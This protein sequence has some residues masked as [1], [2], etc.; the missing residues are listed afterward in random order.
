MDDRKSAVITFPDLPA[1][2]QEDIRDAGLCAGITVIDGD[3]VG[4]FEPD[5][6]PKHLAAYVGHG[7]GLCTHYENYT[8]CREEKEALPGRRLVLFEYTE[9]AL[10]LHYDRISYAYID[11]SQQGYMMSSFALG[12]AGGTVEADIQDF[13]LYFLRQHIYCYEGSCWCEC[14]KVIT[15]IMTGTPDSLSDGRAR[16][17]VEEAIELFGSKPEIFDSNPDFVAARGAAEMGWRATANITYP[18]GI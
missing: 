14:P 6:P 16:Q 1:L 11:H 10:L 8:K 12:S 9:T 5:S 13:F 17:A 2:Y 18:P 3:R 4:P 7:M 15:V